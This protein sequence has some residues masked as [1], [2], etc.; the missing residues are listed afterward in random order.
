MAT[1][2]KKKSA[3]KTSAKPS[4]KTVKK[5][6]STKKTQPQTLSAVAK[7]FVQWRKNK[8]STAEPIP[9]ALLLQA[10]AL[11]QRH[12]N[13]EIGQALSLDSGQLKRASLLAARNLAG[14]GKEFLSIGFEPAATS[15]PKN[16][17]PTMTITLPDT[18]HLTLAQPT[19]EQVTVVVNRLVAE[20]Y[21][22][23]KK[24]SR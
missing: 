20:A 6:A 4:K 12:T 2:T 23:S 17:L 9:D 13:R 8:T 22:Q 3:K 16:T 11:R 19:L 14:V 15:A 18:T 7:Q 5:P 21:T 10:H 1:A 24:K